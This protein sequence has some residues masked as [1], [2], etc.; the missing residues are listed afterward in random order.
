[1]KQRIKLWKLLLINFVLIFVLALVFAREDY[2]DKAARKVTGA[3]TPPNE[4]PHYR[5]TVRIQERLVSQ[6]L[7]SSDVQI[8]LIGDS[9]IE[10]WLTSAV[11]PKS[12][13]LGVSRDDIPGLISRTNTDLVEH[14]PIWYLGIGVNDAFADA[15]IDDIPDY[16]ERLTAIFGPADRLI[17]RA[18]LPVTGESW[19]DRQEEFRRALNSAA[20]LACQDMPNCTFLEPPVGYSTNIAEWTTDGLHPNPVGYQK[21]TEQLCSVIPC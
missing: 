15:V 9:I 10:G 8:A 3:H 2:L 21:L 12:V 4:T 1:M 20:S 13:N 5:T 16:V 17:W 19:N 14:V 11:V 6:A 18:V 7:V